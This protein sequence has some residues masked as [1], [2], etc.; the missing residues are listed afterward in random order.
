ML[1]DV[2]RRAVHRMVLHPPIKQQALQGLFTDQERARLAL[3]LASVIAPADLL[4]RSRIRTRQARIETS[5]KF[6][7]EPTPPPT[8][9][10]EPMPPEKALDY[11][12]ALVPT[13]G[14]DPQRY[15]ADQRRRAFTLAV[16]TE[17]TLLEK[18]QGLLLQGIKEGTSRPGVTTQVQQILDAVG[19]SPSNPQYSEMVVRTNLMDAYNQGQTDELADPDVKEFFPVWRYDGI[20]DGREGDDHRPH[21]G[22]YYPSTVAFSVVRG[23]RVYNCR[24]TQTPIDRYTWEDLQNKGI[25]LS[26]DYT[27]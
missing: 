4:G 26:D 16:A 18:I 9:S 12:R 7:D 13:L 6:A 11:F 17:K 10:L 27:P 2:V 22:Q 3:G 15:G 25:T 23:K 8:D 19:V 24:C 21:F 5:R 14:I 1:A 20:H